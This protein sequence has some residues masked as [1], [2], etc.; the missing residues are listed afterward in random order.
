MMIWAMPEGWIAPIAIPRIMVSKTGIKE[1]GAAS[2]EY[3]L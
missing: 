2:S 1:K 3:V